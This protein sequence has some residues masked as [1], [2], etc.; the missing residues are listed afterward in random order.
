MCA[1]TPLQAEPKVT[2]CCVLVFQE[3]EV[4]HTLEKSNLSQGPDVTIRVLDDMHTVL[5]S[6]GRNLFGAS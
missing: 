6:L 2:P 4:R 3:I 5:G 1:V